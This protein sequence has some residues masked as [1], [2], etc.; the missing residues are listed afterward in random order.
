MTTSD[1]LRLA[2]AAALASVVYATVWVVWVPWALLGRDHLAAQ[3]HDLVR[4]TVERELG[5]PVTRRR[6]LVGSL[7]GIVRSTVRPFDRDHLTAVV[8][9]DTPTWARAV[10]R[11]HALR[12]RRAQRALRRGRTPRPQHEAA[13]VVVAR[14][15]ADRA[16]TQA[17]ALDA[18]RA[19]HDRHL[20]AFD[21]AL[22]DLPAGP[23]RL[24]AVRR[25]EQRDDTVRGSL[26]E[27]L[28]DRA[29][30]ALWM[31]YIGATLDLLGRGV[32][33]GFVLG[34]AVT[35]AFVPDLVVMAG[36]GGVGSLVGMVGAA[37]ALVRLDLRAIAAAFGD[38]VPDSLRLVTA[39]R[40][41][42]WVGALAPVVTV[43]IVAVT[44]GLR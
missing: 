42:R 44:A 1:L 21:A 38:D 36:W 31:P 17:R 7:R 43:A 26:A 2:A 25:L 29:L 22:A 14:T 6:A 23:G 40:L 13:A 9:G 24:E 33:L 35:G 39:T 16:S 41:G 10:S 12:A 28:G 37:V 19:R 3:R 11:G 15:H 5:G 34:V 18:V 32:T 27:L 8:S 30:R 20:R 4:D